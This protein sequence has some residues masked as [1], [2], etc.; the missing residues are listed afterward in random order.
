M[1]NPV[2]N[3]TTVMDF[4]TEEDEYLG[5]GCAGDVRQSAMLT[6]LIGQQIPTPRQRDDEISH[7]SG[8]SFRLVVWGRNQMG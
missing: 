3:T 4:F 8:G 7:D 2:N 1:I 5:P 6:S